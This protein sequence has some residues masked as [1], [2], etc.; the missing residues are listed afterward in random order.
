MRPVCHSVPVYLNR[1]GWIKLSSAQRRELEKLGKQVKRALQS[2]KLF[3]ER[4]PER[5]HR[6]RLSH[7]AEIRQNKI[8]AGA[9]L[10]APPGFM[11][12][13]V[14]RKIAPV[15]RM[16]LFTQNFDEAET[17]LDEDTARTLRVAGHAGASRRR[18]SAAQGHGEGT[19]TNPPRSQ[20]NWQIP[21]EL[22]DLRRVDTIA[23]DTETNDAGL[24]ADRGSSWPWGDGYVCERRLARRR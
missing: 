1:I 11:W 18:G 17:D 16:R 15:V 6:V 10:D 9:P 24:R 23:I 12:V 13:T 2:D 14:V 3:F 8:I 5:M 21:R 20:T 19:M 22:P 4:R 7:S